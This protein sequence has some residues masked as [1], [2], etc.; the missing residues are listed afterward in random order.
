MSL[1]IPK[2]IHQIWLGPLEPPQAA[3]DSWKKKHPEWAYKLWTDE[4]LPDLQNYEAFKASDNYPQKSDILRYELLYR[5]GGIFVDADEY[6]LKPID[7]LFSL[8]ESKEAEVFAVHEGNKGLPDLIANG[9][10]GCIEGSEFMKKM[11]DEVDVDQEG[12]AWE[13]VGPLYLTRMLDVYAPKCEVLPSKT[14]FPVHHRDKNMRK[15]SAAQFAGDPEVYGIQLWGS[16]NFA[17]KPDFLKN[18]WMSM[19]YWSRKI[20][21]KMFVVTDLD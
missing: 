10:M 19:K 11:I 1:G 18:P 2:I 13:I 8:I 21:G 6:C 12:D 9:V 3:M 17:Y 16:T 5:F 4:N 14:F 15:I 20:R 7:P